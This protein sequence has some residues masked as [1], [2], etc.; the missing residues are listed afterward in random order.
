MTPT[1]R[2]DHSTS[3]RRL[4]NVLARLR[5]GYRHF[6]LDRRGGTAVQAI[7]FLPVILLT[8]VLAIKLWQVILIRRSLHSGTYLATRYLSL[9]PPDSINPWDWQSVAEEFII[10]EMKNNPFTDE[11]KL[12][13]GNPFMIV[14][15]NL[16][17]DGYACKQHFTVRAEYHVFGAS[18]GESGGEYVLPNMNRIVLREERLGEVLC[19]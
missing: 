7:V 18:P 5:R 14:E 15:V 6:V 10:A 13:P 3:D 1:Y 17:D 12:K 2:T 8:F 19:D 9:Y 11:T 16:L 4:G